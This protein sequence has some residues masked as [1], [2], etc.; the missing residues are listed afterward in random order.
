MELRRIGRA[1]VTGTYGVYVVL[2]DV[3]SYS[4]CYDFGIPFGGEIVLEFSS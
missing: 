1:R 2:E 4:V 3:G